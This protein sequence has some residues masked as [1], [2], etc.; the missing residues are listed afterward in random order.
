MR[1]FSYGGIVGGIGLLL[2][3]VLPSFI[4][5]RRKQSRWN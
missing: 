3:L 2:G 4:P 1:W 5:N